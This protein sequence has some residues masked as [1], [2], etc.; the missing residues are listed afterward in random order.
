MLPLGSIGTVGCGTG[1]ET[2]T[3]VTP[4]PIAITSATQQMESSK[5]SIAAF[6]ENWFWSKSR[7]QDG[8]Y[9]ET[10]VSLDLGGKTP[11]IV[12]GLKLPSKTWKE[13]VDYLWRNGR[14]P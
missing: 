13:L 1:K 7:S 8:K 9:G 5:G 10:K 11:A 14:K 4:T 6:A 3:L 12:A 2:P